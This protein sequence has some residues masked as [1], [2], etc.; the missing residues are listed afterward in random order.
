MQ[1]DD[2][3]E[4]VCVGWAATDSEDGERAVRKDGREA[5][6]CGGR[7]GPDGDI[8][9]GSHAE[10]GI[11]HFL[12]APKGKHQAGSIFASHQAWEV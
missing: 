3:D 1:H 10:I 4:L 7:D 12:L 2:E 8:R 6:T 5:G 11:T 9:S